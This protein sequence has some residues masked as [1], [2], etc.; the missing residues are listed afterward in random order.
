VLAAALTL[1]LCA[2]LMGVQEPPSYLRPLALDTAADGSG[3][4]RGPMSPK[5]SVLREMWKVCTHPPVALCF[6]IHFD[7]NVFIVASEAVVVPV[8]QHAVNL[9]FS[10]LQNSYVYAAGAVYILALT[11]MAMFLAKRTSDRGLVLGACI[12]YMGAVTAALFLWEYEMPLWRFLLGEACLLTPFPFA[13]SPNRALFIKL[14]SGSQHQ[15]LL[16]SCL[17]VMGSLGAVL[18]PLWMGLS[19]G[20]PQPSGPVAPMMFWGLLTL[21]GTSTLLVLCVWFLL[22]PPLQP[23]RAGGKHEPL[24]SEHTATDPGLAHSALLRGSEQQLESDD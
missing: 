17:G 18:G 1:L 20:T 24:V 22:Y 3:H 8:T 7:Y 23:D 5:D 16:S 19:A 11:A 13:L 12:L 4:G 6:L 2:V 9:R 21:C 10:P 14:V 15:G